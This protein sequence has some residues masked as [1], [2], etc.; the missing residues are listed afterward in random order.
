MT[1]TKTEAKNNPELIR[2]D[3][4]GDLD[5]ALAPQAAG[6]E[7]SGM[8]RYRLNDGSVRQLL[9]KFMKQLPFVATVGVG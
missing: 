5:I 8:I 3:R 2:L 4:L 7:R 9:Q 1:T 6:V